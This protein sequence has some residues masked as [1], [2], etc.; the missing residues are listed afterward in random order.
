MTRFVRLHTQTFHFFSHEHEKLFYSLSLDSLSNKEAGTNEN[1]EVSE[2]DTEKGKDEIGEP[3]LTPISSRNVLSNQQKEQI[4]SSIKAHQSPTSSRIYPAKDA[5]GSAKDLKLQKSPRASPVSSPS[6][7]ARSLTKKEEALQ[8]ELSLGVKKPLQ[9]RG[10]LPS[11]RK[12]ND[13]VT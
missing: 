9:R 5:S 10:A 4:T 7:S 12:R 1:E 8:K 13:L 3:T 6:S 2:S 11:K